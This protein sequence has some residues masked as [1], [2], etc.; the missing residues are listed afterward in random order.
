MPEYHRPRP[1]AAGDVVSELDCGIEVLDRWLRGWARHNEATGGSRTFVSVA[2][3]TDRVAGYYCLSASS[4]VRGEAPGSVARRMPDLIPAALLS[5]FA[6]D[7]RDAGAGLGASLLQDAVSRAIQASETL[8]MR[9]LIV[10]AKDDDVVPFYERFGFRRFPGGSERILYLKI[11]DA[12]KTAATLT[13][14]T[15]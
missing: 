8:G 3:D 4:I 7:R 15:R 12:L 2:A 9:A 14:P 6:V 10:N 1:L 5:R 13:P 11:A